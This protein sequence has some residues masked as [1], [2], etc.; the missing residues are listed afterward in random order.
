MDADKGFLDVLFRDMEVGD[1]CRTIKT[2]QLVGYRHFI[3]TGTRN[4]N[5]MKLEKQS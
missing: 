1:F 5:R 2:I 4:E 3:Y